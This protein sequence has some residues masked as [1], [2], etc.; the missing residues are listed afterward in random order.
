MQRVISRDLWQVI[1]RLARK[2]SRRRAAISYVT[3]DLVGFKAGDVLVVDASRRSIACGETS[4]AVL[5]DLHRRGV[6]IHSCADL[7]A[8]VFLFDRVAVVASAN[9]S[10]SSRQT[11]IEAGVATDAV[12]VVSGV[13]SFIEQLVS[14][15]PRLSERQIKGLC[16]IPVVRRRGRV[17]RRTRRMPRPR[18]LGDQTWLVGVRE[19]AHDPV[20][21]E[22]KAIDRSRS[23]QIEAPPTR[24]GRGSQLDQMDG[25]HA[26]GAR[27]S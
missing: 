6:H 3:R 25:Q 16:S 26:L 23:G 18:R 1:R 4:A 7:H 11:L 9:M 21:E 8:K 12:T 15:T 5:Q 17:R 2:A 22:Q 10:E 27:V 19:L 20:P 24:S 14:V 13:A